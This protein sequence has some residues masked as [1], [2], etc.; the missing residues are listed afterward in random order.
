MSPSND[1]DEEE[2]RALAPKDA[3]PVQTCCDDGSEVR[4]KGSGATRSKRQ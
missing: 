1:Y 3:Q 4:G 2:A